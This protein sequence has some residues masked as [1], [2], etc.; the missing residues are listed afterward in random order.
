MD[1][2]ILTIFTDPMMGLTYECTPVFDRLKNHYGD[3]LE[4]KYIM[5]GLVRDVSDFMTPEERAL[6]PVES[7]RTYCRRLAQIY[8][9]EEPIGGL[10]IN[11]EGFHLFDAEHRSSYP[12]DVA[13]KAAQLA[14]P[15]KADLYLKNLQLATIV[16]TRQTTLPEE[17]LS[18]AVETGIDPAA[19]RRHF[20][21]GSAEAAFRE[22]LQFTRSLGIYSL[23]T[24]LLR[25]RD[26]AMFI[27]QL[28]GFEDFIRAIT[29]L[30]KD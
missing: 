1:K 15:E 13:Y 24:F 29:K 8:K 16:E 9:S 20:E 27:R 2:I 5:A 22:D 17:L 28:A 11:M 12:L 18:I 30:I 6:E 25:Y 26:R 23:P 21:D 19:F 4:I 3:Q 7:V 14:D 10:P